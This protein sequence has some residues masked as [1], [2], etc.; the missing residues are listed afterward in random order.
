MIWEGGI[1][2][3]QSWLPWETPDLVTKVMKHTS[4]TPIDS[5][6]PQKC[7]DHVI[8]DDK[9]QIW[10]LRYGHLNFACLKSLV[11]NA[12]VYGL[13]KVQERKHVCVRCAMRKN[14]RSSF[15]KDQAWKAFNLLQLVHSDICGPMQ[16]PSIDKSIYFL[17]LIDDCTSMCCIYFLK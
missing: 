12:I 5:Q 10:H 14:S 7:L 4:F 8:V 2:S 3:L 11:P 6:T 15:A 16:T 1:F 17:T 9:S 13:P